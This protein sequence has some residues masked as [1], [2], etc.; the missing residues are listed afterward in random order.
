M[1]SEHFA[2]GAGR[3]LAGQTVDVDLLVFMFF[4]HELLL[5]LWLH[6]NKSARYKKNITFNV[7]IAPGKFGCGHKSLVGLY[8]RFLSISHPFV[9]SFNIYLNILAVKKVYFKSIFNLKQ[10]VIKMS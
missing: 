6:A 9:V 1:L 8:N 2:H 7:K 3:R 4:T 5:L 10:P